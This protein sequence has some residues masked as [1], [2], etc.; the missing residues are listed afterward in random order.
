MEIIKRFITIGVYEDLFPKDDLFPRNDEKIRN[1][2]FKNLNK[3]IKIYFKQ[4]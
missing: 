4:R 2:Y 3:N 1:T